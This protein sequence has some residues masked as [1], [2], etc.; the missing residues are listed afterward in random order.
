M[1]VAGNQSQAPNYEA[2]QINDA[3]TALNI[4]NKMFQE[5]IYATLDVS[6]IFPASNKKE[7]ENV[8]FIKECKLYSA[9]FDTK[10]VYQ[11]WGKC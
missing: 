8:R 2:P 1:P 10:Y 4:F 6:K 3:A 5:E 9:A 7:P 11:I